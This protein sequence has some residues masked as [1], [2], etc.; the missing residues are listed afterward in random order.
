[1]FAIGEKLY[2]PAD[3]DSRAACRAWGRF[4]SAKRAPGRHVA[5][6]GESLPAA[7]VPPQV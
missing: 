3:H 2:N 5:G 1:V 6:V 4:A 7:A